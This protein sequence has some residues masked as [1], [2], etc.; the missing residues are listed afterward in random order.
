MVNYQ[1]GKIYKIVDNTNGNIYVGSTCEKSLAR[2][3]QTHMTD[4]KKYLKGEKSSN[5][6]LQ[7]FKNNNYDIILI[8]NCPCENK[9][10][11]HARERYFIETLICVNYQRPGRTPKEYKEENKYKIEEYIKQY[12]INNK[13]KNEETKKQY[14][15]KNKKTIIENS[16]LFKTLCLCG[17]YRNGHKTR[18][19]QTKFHQNYIL[20]NPI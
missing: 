12:N 6:A 17:M 1:L 5:T 19:E 16:K 20:N 8:E 18:H 14:Y 7:I 13:E 4:Y 3:L 15:L 10:T 2:R 9:D 11:L